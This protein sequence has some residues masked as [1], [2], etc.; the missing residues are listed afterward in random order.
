[1]MAEIAG[2]FW[3]NCLVL[4]KMKNLRWETVILKINIENETGY[5]LK[6]KNTKYENNSRNIDV[7][8]PDYLSLKYKHPTLLAS[9]HLW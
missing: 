1:L 2:S 8:L 4:L 5:V 3:D 6:G 9:W 7:S